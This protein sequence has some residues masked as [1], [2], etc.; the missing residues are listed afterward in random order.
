MGLI[1][2]DAP[3]MHLMFA[4]EVEKHGKLFKFNMMGQENAVVTGDLSLKALNAPRSRQKGMLEIVKPVGS[5][6]FALPQGDL[7]Q[8]LRKAWRPFLM[9]TKYQDTITRVLS[10]H[11]LRVHDRFDGLVGKGEVNIDR[12]MQI[13]MFDALADLTFGASIDSNKEPKFFEAWS[14]VLQ[15][16]FWDFSINGVGYWKLY[17]TEFRAKY[18]EAY[19]VIKGFIADNISRMQRELDTEPRE[20]TSIM[21]FYLRSND[22]TPL[23]FEEL[24]GH[25]IN[26]FWGAYDSTRFIITIGLVEGAR[27]PEAKQRVAEEFAKVSGGT[28]LPSAAELERTSM[29]QLHAFTAEVLRLYPPFPVLFSELA[30]DL[31]IGGVTLPSGTGIIGVTWSEQ[32]D[33]AIW[34]ADA[35]TFRPQRWIEHYKIHTAD[36]AAFILFGSGPRSCPGERIAY[37]DVRLFLGTLMRDFDFTFSKQPEVVLEVS[38]QAKNA[39]ATISRSSTKK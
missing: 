30:A 34:G 37:F 35:E 31:E 13:A 29:P 33:P 22:S 26:W 8:A 4:R 18:E 11:A 39:M 10:V 14:I 6:L 25:A 17:K 7:H 1:A 5:G 38:L 2:A 21:D 23:T 27:N 3:H 12:E 16:V 24:Q 20:P 36:P 9:S 32:R 19:G 15:W 28:G